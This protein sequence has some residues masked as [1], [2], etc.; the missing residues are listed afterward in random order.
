MVFANSS[1]QG[2]HFSGLLEIE[3]QGCVGVG[4]GVGRGRLGG[5]GYRQLRRR[6]L[7]RIAGVG[8]GLDAGAEGEAQK[9]KDNGDLHCGG[10]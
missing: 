9:E 6:G 8:S 7:V 4:V 2:G 1:T 3:K 5:S 10:S